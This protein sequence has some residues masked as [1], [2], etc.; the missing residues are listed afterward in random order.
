MCYSSFP[1]YS[2]AKTSHRQYKWYGKVKLTKYEDFWKP[3][4]LKRCRP[5]PN[6]PPHAGKE[7]GFPSPHAKK[8]NQIPFPACGG[9]L[10]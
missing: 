2:N 9:G 5:H 1:K 4:H 7:I 6:L 3:L 10:G 8:E